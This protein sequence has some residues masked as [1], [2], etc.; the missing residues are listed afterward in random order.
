VPCEAARYATSS[1]R[2]K[3]ICN[4]GA[5]A[6]FGDAYASYAGAHEYWPLDGAMVAYDRGIRR[7]AMTP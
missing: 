5:D 3:Y 6:T 2:G 4:L 7:Q 1:N